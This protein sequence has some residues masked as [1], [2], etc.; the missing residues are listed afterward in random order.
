MF[1]FD[2]YKTPYLAIIV[3]YDAARFYKIGMWANFT[4]HIAESFEV[5]EPQFHFL[6]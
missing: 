4:Q 5:I 6:F 3:K 1:P 2:T